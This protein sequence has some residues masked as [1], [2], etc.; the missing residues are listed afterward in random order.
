MGPKSGAKNGVHIHADSRLLDFSSL[1]LQYSLG[2]NSAFLR[3]LLGNQ[4]QQGRHDLDKLMHAVV[5][6]VLAQRAQL[7]CIGYQPCRSTD[8]C[9]FATAWLRGD[10]LGQGAGRRRKLGRWSNMYQG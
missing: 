6:S 10:T 7:A 2:Y 1:L 8:P 4:R 9:G 3:F 5:V